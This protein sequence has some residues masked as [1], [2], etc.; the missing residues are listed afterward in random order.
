MALIRG[1]LNYADLGDADV[2]IEAV[3][4]KPRSQAEDFQGPR[5]GHEAGRSARDQYLD[6]RHRSDRRGH[7][8]SRRCDRI[9]FLLAGERHALARGGAHR[10]HRPGGDPNCVGSGENLAQDARAGAGLLWLHRQ[11]HDGG[12]RPRGAAHGAGRRDAAPSRRCARRHGAWRWASWPYSTWPASTWGSTC[13][14]PT[15]TDIRRILP[16]IR[17]MSRCTPP[18]RLGQK[19]GKGYYRYCPATGRAT[20]IRR[21]STFSAAARA[22]ARYTAARPQCR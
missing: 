18:G 6:A 14:G 1:S 15:P 5:R 7:P 2:V 3:Y 17:R 10:C 20:M 12:I 11:S 16:T 13:I 8:A 22:T 21:P 4:R 19:N 9:A